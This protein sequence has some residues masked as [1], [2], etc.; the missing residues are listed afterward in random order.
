MGKELENADLFIDPAEFASIK[1][2]DDGRSDPSGKFPRADY[3][4][5]SSVNNIAT[6]V[7]TKSVYLG[8]GTK[9]VD[10]EIQ[11]EP[12]ANYTMNQVK[13][14][15]SGHIVEY[16]DT[17]G[18]ERIMLRQKTGS[19]V[20]MRADG[21]VIISS[22]K[23]SIKVT[24]AD[25]KVIVEG[26][27]EIVYNGNLSM[28]VAGD[29][30]LEVGGNYSVKVAGE[31]DEEVL[32][33]YTQE[34]TKNHTKTIKGSK[35]E[36]IKGSQT[37]TIM[38]NK[39]STVKGDFEVDINGIFEQNVKSEY[40][41]TSENG[42]IISTENAIINAS[43]LSVVGDSGTIGGHEIVYYGKTAH[44]P[45]VNSTSMHA[46]TFH[47]DLTGV[48][49]KANEANKAG[50]AA[51]GPSGSGGTPTVTTATDK[52][53]TKPD[54][55]ITTDL[56]NKSDLGI[57][58]IQIDPNDDFVNTIDLSANYGGVSPVRLST[59]KARSKLRDPNNL[60][61][62]TFTGAIVSEGLIS[63]NFAVPTPA[64]FGRI[65]GPE[66]NAMIG[67]E[68][69]GTQ[70]GL[71]KRFKVQSG[72]TNFFFRTVF[73]PDHKYN[74]VFQTDINPRTRLADGITLSK[75]LGSHADPVTMNHLTEVAE[76]KN[77][78]KQYMLHAEAMK[79]INFATGT[80]EFENFRLEV[81]EGMY[82]PESG[83]NLDKTDGINH[84]LT[85]GQAVVYGLYGLD[86]EVAIE[87]TFDLA[88]YWKDHVNFDK[89]ILD[90]DTY[91]PDGSLHACIILIMPKILAPWT[92]TY[93]NKIETR[94]NNVVQTT[95]E[96]LEI[97]DETE[98]IE[99]IVV[100]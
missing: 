51:L 14:T 12:A 23:N 45:R 30:N 44:I 61:N 40:T 27:G 46:T 69:I 68:S 4:G 25:E 42:V 10:L 89:M 34:V 22:T 72:E 88:L 56:L 2:P 77:L 53:T 16:D 20:E 39:F 17:F 49:E 85:S 66:K 80:S 26:D 83:E 78:A 86:G 70:D 63:K 84:L 97:L 31:I 99:N 81:L 13:Q 7:N 94:F 73:V 38:G 82:V 76:R 15:A 91:N 65:V 58:R 1:D 74:P 33:S 48:A 96:L 24:A 67:T 28:R 35:A 52:N 60:K 90:Y 29:F 95:E 8:G 18:R 87:K 36:S 37:E 5:V 93:N 54:T 75:F 3:V 41:L 55:T 98:N 43:S 9:G 19:G 64:K 57:R 79:T 47:G 59:E 92:V 62:K 11:E 50:T 100:T 6:G 71:V 21:S 32:G